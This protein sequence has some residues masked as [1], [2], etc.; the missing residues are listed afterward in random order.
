MTQALF[1]L[2]GLGKA[3]NQKFETAITCSHDS[4]QKLPCLCI[5]SVVKGSCGHAVLS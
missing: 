4:S 1:I 3:Y 2:N 5:L